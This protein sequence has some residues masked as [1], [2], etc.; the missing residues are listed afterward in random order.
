MSACSSLAEQVKA[1]KAGTAK[2]KMEYDVF[3]SYSHKNLATAKI[4]LD[5]IK[6]KAPE[7]NVFFD[8]EELQTGNYKPFLKK[9]CMTL[10]ESRTRLILGDKYA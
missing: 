7:L 9:I 10:P 3:I 2:V 4:V 6:A 5:T 1:E 8:Y